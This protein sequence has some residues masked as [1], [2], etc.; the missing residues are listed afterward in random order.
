MLTKSDISP[1]G[2]GK[3]FCLMS[4]PELVLD[5]VLSCLTVGQ[6][7][8]DGE[9]SLLPSLHGRMEGEKEG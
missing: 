5:D 4:P 6:S 7:H 9:S 1:L 3:W 2:G 8:F